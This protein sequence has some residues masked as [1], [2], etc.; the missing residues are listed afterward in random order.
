M[1]QLRQD[2]AW[3]RADDGRLTPF[4]S[5]RLT[6]SIEQACEF[7]GH[8]DRLLAE[9][10]A[11]AVRHYALECESDHTIAAAEISRIV[12]AVLKALT[13]DNIA[14]AYAR[15]REWTEIRLDEITGF[16][17]EF[18]RQLDEALRAASGA[19]ETSMMQLRGLRACVMRLRNAQ[20]WGAS[21]RAL[22]DEIVEFVR[23]RV[24]RSRPASAGAL[25]MEV[26]E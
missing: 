4:D 10:V 7:A 12:L 17:L 19:E 16:E 11:A 25:R 1:I 3:V 15:R 9:S 24:T 8:A 20:R 6:N 14:R 18:Y 22:A 5:A 26:L 21:C 23:A 13:C 2:I